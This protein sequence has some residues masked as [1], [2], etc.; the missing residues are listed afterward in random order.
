MRSMVEGAVGL[1][2][3]CLGVPSRQEWAAR[4]YCARQAVASARSWPLAMTEACAAR[5]C[6]D[7]LTR[8]RA[9]PGRC[10]ACGSPRSLDLNA[11]EG[12]E[13]AHLDCDAF[14]ASVE[15][16]DNPA[17]RDEAVIVGGL[18]RRGVVLTCCYGARAYGV[19]SA[20]PMRQALRL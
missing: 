17:L 12:L 14:Y 10:P 9:E 3:L 2:A 8:W 16:R 15:K 6:R 19:R 11:A 13:I 7:C 20:M 4:R 1:N 18:S 5:L